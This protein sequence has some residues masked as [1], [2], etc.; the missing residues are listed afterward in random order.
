MSKEYD[1]ALSFA[2]EDRQYAKEL[3]DLLDAGKY[4][5]FYD[6]Y[7]LVKLWGENLYEHLSS[8]YKDQALYCVMFLSEHYERKLWTNHERQSA[9]A[10]AFEENQGYIL[11]VRIDDRSGFIT[12]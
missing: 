6:E 5:V 7:E 4:S 11:P 9:Q 10:R 8:V 2:G 12:V 1:V 3:A